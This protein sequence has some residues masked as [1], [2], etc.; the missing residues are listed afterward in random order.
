[1]IR[2]IYKPDII[3]SRLILKPKLFCGVVLLNAK[4][5][6]DLVRAFSWATLQNKLA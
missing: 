2:A 6:N 1:M 3:V 5:L 4:E